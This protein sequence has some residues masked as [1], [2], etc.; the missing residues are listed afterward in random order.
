[1]CVTHLWREVRSQSNVGSSQEDLINPELW[2]KKSVAKIKVPTYESNQQKNYY[3]SV[4][5]A[6][7][8]T[9]NIKFGKSNLQLYKKLSVVPKPDGNDEL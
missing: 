4:K 8:P 2:K 9:E 1:M 6:P 7:I 3:Q 5:M